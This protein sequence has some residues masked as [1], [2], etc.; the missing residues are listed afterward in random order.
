MRCTE[1]YLAIPFYD[2]DITVHVV[3]SDGR[4]TEKHCQHNP[5]DE[6]DTAIVAV[7]GS[8]DCATKWLGKQRQRSSNV[9][10]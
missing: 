7:L 4:G 2:E 9:S 5:F 8:Q 3:Y 10:N 1:C 6:D